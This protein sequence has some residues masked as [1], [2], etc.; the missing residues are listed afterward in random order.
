MDPEE[1][2]N[3]K[4]ALGRNWTKEKRYAFDFAFD[5]E[6]GQAEIFKHTTRFLV[7]GILHGFN[8]TVFA[9]GATG[10]GKTYT[11]IGNTENPGNMVM[12]LKELFIKMNELKRENRYNVRVSFLEIY[13]EQIWDLIVTSTDVL[14]LREDPEKGI[15]VAGLSEV[16]VESPEDIMELLQF[17]NQNRT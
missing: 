8:A 7:E 16:E 12:T 13:N 11:M 2:M 9:Y 15:T 17:G 4:G 1:L 10:A 3:C 5:K 6:S 14:D